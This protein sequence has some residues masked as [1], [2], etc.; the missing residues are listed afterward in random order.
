M[1]GSPFALSTEMSKAEQNDRE[2]WS[3]YLTDAGKR[4]LDLGYCAFLAFARR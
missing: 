4:R 3:C 1:S 2:A